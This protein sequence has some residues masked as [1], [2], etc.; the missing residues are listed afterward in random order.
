MADGGEPALARQTQGQHLA[1]GQ[2]HIDEIQ[3]FGGTAHLGHQLGLDGAGALGPHEE[4][5][6]LAQL[7]RQ[8]QEQHQHTHAAHPLGQRAPQQHAAGQVGH[9]G[10]GGRAGGGQAGDRLEQGV[11]ITVQNAGEHIGKR[12]EQC[13]QHPAEGHCRKAVA[14]VHL[15]LFHRDQMQHRARRGTEQ[16]RQEKLLPAGLGINTGRQCRQQQ[17]ACLDPQDVAHCV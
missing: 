5:R 3:Y 9:G 2:H 12:A 15:G 17:E 4:H 1:E 14:A 16:R 10:E 7:R 13:Q 8:R 6:A 11:D